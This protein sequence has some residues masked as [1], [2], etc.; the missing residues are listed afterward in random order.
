MIL[1]L[2]IS[3]GGRVLAAV[4]QVAV[5]ALLARS[6]G[7]DLFGSFTLITSYTLLALAVLDFGMA[8]RVLRGIHTR[9]DRSELTTFAVA[10]AFT[11][12]ILMGTMALAAGYWRIDAILAVVTVL[13]VVGES[14]GDVAVAIQQGRKRSGLAM[15]ILLSRRVSAFLPVAIAPGQLGAEISAA[16]AGL[17]GIAW[18]FF[19]TVKIFSKPAALHVLI[20]KNLG[21]I[22][23]GG[24]TSFAQLDAPIIGFNLGAAG[25]GLYGA[26]LRLLNPLNLAVTTMLQVV[27]PELASANQ[28]EDRIRV[29]RRVRNTVLVFATALAG[30]SWAAPN[31]IVFLYGEEFAGAAPV[32]VAVFI[33]AALAAVSQ[34]HMTWF[35]STR[36]PLSVPIAMW[37]AVSIGLGAI[38]LLS[39]AFGLT[40]AAAGLVLMHAL[41]TAVIVVICN[42]EIR[43]ITG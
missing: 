30:L 12:L 38:F 43:R 36:V 39:W 10:R 24:A 22:A 27:I 4:V 35:Y 2:V 16:V 14:T 31:L 41:T 18:F 29:F 28:D 11:L 3:M 1:R 19:T 37:T 7:V 8:T 6:L 34:V 17:C 25:A 40:G 13:Y 20:R 15:T 42:S 26:A 9:A 5:F 21:I 32:A 33:C 23:S